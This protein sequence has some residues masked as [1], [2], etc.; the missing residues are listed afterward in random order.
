M[1]RACIACCLFFF[2]SVPAFG[3]EIEWETKL[4]RATAKAAASDPPKLVLLHF[5]AQWCRPCKQMETFVFSNMMV[6]SAIADRC[7]PLKI[8]VD[9]H[10][11][12]AKEYGVTAVPFDVAMTATG[13]IVM[14]RRS[15]LDSFGY[16]R[17]ISLL[18]E[19]EGNS[20]AATIR[21]ELSELQAKLRFNQNSLANREMAFKQSAPTATVSPSKSFS[22]QPRYAQSDQMRVVKNPFFDPSKVRTERKVVGAG[23]DGFV[24]QSFASPRA[25]VV[26]ADAPAD[27]TQMPESNRTLSP[28][29][30][31][32]FPVAAK[33]S[34]SAKQS[35]PDDALVAPKMVVP[36]DEVASSLEPLK[37][38][39][40]ESVSQKQVAGVAA[41]LE[42]TTLLAR[43]DHDASGL[44]RAPVEQPARFGLQ[45]KCPVTLALES[46][47]VDGDELFGCTHRGTTYLF[48][49]A[50]KLKTFQTNPDKYSP[51][52]AGY[53][54]VTFHE[55]GELAEGLEEFGVFMGAVGD[56]Q[57]VLF[58]NSVNRD[59]FKAKPHLYLDSIRVAT[60]NADGRIVR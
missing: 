48:A 44:V 33:Q 28:V 55:S 51:M 7:I 22:M 46:R 39:P 45:R 5:T 57:I 54:P 38:N 59:K 8:D 12:L 36:V 3:Q 20:E 41:T 37:M 9:E 30:N 43:S 35:L 32:S 1:M 29:F 17:M 25:Q 16:A 27:Q 31:N 23:E 53:D 26:A 21:R 19:D 60:E 58:A 34:V 6:Q 52:L 10:P 40:P 42:E 18:T 15:P 49:D 14:N 50:E 4:A 11:E 47:W 56:Q 13:R 2:F 24:D